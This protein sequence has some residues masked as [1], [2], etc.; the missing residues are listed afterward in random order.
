MA[1]L[2]VPTGWVL[3]ETFESET[4]QNALFREWQFANFL[5]AFGFMTQVAMLAECADHH[6]NWSNVYNKVSIHLTSHDAGNTVT[7]RDINL[8]RKINALG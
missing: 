6:P 7:E 3:K 8:A 1:E 5:E 2:D 4:E